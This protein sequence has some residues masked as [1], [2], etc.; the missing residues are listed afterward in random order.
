MGSHG[1]EVSPDPL[2]GGDRKALKKELVKSRAMAGIL[3]EQ[4]EQKWRVGEA[5]IR[6]P[7]ISPAKAGTKKYG[8]TAVRSTRR[9]PSSRRLTAASRGWKSNARDARRRETLTSASCGDLRQL[10][11]MIL[12]AA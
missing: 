1:T 11:F 5:L 3:A 9:L 8:A 2:Y 6:R 10:A 12:P 4:S 7:T